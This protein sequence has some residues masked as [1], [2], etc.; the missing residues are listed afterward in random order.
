MRTS[1]V[2]ALA[3]GV[4]ACAAE[5][6]GASTVVAADPNAPVPVVRYV[7]VMTGTVDYRPVDPRPWGEMNKRVAPGGSR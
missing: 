6:P 2:V 1:L 7:P 3:A 5:P 4:S